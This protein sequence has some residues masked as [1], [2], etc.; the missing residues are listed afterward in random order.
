MK[1][2]I[3]VELKKKKE[4][5]FSLNCFR[6]PGS[7]SCSNIPTVKGKY[8]SPLPIPIQDFHPITQQ[9]FVIYFISITFSEIL[10]AHN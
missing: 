8:L 10:I 7:M 9:H 2:S 1:F 4:N 3:L 5:G 6:Y